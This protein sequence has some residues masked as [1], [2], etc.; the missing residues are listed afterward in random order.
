[1]T[2]CLHIKVPLGVTRVRLEDFLFDRF[3]GLSRMYLR[4]VV[5]N[6]KC[7]INGRLENKG[8]R[9]SGGDFIEI[10]LDLSRETAMRPQ[11]MPL[12]IV[13]EDNDLIVVNKPAGI[14]VHP[15]HR[16]KSGTLL[17]ALTFYLN[18][19]CGVRSAELKPTGGS[20]SE[21]RVPHSALV[22]PG[23]VHRLDKETSG[24][25]VIAKSTRVHRILARQFQ[26][27]TVEKKYLA[28]VDGVVEQDEG[29]ITGTIGRY[30]E[31]KR[32][33]LKA[34][35]KISETHYRVRKRNN[36]TTLLELEPITGRTNQLRIHCASI[37][38][39]IVGDTKRGGSESER[40][41]LHAYKLAFRHP[42]GGRL[43]AFETKNPLIF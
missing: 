19:E 41:C 39:P 30:A 22:R 26:R 38:H 17:N 11:E 13:Y 42:D 8:K 14:L 15:T 33:D 21:F 25:I 40:L 10:E 24:L 28:L 36:D 6:K 35:G 18:A 43:V 7:E 32:W 16:D 27:K 12:D 5:K 9:V 29:K 20:D 2:E 34:D 3:P 1:M 4:D 23:L 31:E 37:G